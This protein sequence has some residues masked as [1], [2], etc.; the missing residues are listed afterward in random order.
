MEDI[1]NLHFDKLLK[2][3]ATFGEK[4]KRI[5]LLT[6]SAGFLVP[7]KKHTESIL[8]YPDFTE[9]V[10]TP[11]K[12]SSSVQDNSSSVQVVP[13]LRSDQFEVDSAVKQTEH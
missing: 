13:L 11:E 9:C 6:L 10:Q 1:Q 8:Q 3:K 5:D 7:F 2:K 12:H 4:K